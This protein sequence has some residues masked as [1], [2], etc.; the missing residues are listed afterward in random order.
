ML[1]M[2]MRV[3]PLKGDELVR[4]SSFEPFRMAWYFHLHR[5]WLSFSCLSFIFF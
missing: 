1:V 4:L 5:R 3:D 2:F